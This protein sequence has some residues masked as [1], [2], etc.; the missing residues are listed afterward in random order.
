MVLPTGHGNSLIYAILPMVFDYVMGKATEKAIVYYLEQSLYYCNIGRQG[1]I[2]VVV[3]PL[4]ALMMD[5]KQRFLNRGITVEYVGEAQTDN[6][7]VTAVMSGK[8]QLVY[9]SPENILNNYRFRNMICT[10]E[11]QKLV[12]L[13][14]DEAHCIKM[15]Y[16]C[17]L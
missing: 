10:S 2:V 7:A 6:H 14:V 3:T 15:W 11:Y 4:V 5:Q 1:S 16:V 17:I 13:A 8:V 12:T 9:I